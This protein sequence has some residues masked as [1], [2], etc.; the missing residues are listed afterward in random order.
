MV[1]KK[2]KDDSTL[3]KPKREI[4]AAGAVPAKKAK[5]V[6]NKQPKGEADEK[7]V[8][9]GKAE[10]PDG[11]LVRI[12]VFCDRLNQICDRRPSVIRSGRGRVG[13]I[14]A[15]FGIH[16]TSAYRLLN[17]LGLPN[18][19]LLWK[20]ADEFDVSESW[21]LGRGPSNV[22]DLLDKSPVQ[23][24][25]FNPRSS[26]VGNFATVPAGLLPVGFD[27][28][29]LIYSRVITETGHDEDVL[30]RLT[31]EPQEGKV[32]L[33]FDPS[34]DHTH[35]R[36]VNIDF[37]K[38]QLMCSTTETAQISMIPQDSVVYGQTQDAKK[39]SILGPVVARVVYGFKGD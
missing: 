9:P 12:T 14:A 32:H 1:T 31:A 23:I 20:M 36:R 21:L 28:S 3:P 16:Y 27:S 6:V 15:K 39:L 33:F 25:V 30:V 10:K 7:P 5:A 18:C 13:D 17:A 11:D 19:E 26:E 22:D 34:N 8:K 29:K 2:S 4:K 37:A 35:L 24:H 38:R